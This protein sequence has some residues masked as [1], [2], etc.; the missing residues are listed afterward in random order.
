MELGS[1]CHVSAPLPN[2]EDTLLELRSCCNRKEE[3]FGV[4]F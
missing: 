2:R 3:T 4:L 1:D